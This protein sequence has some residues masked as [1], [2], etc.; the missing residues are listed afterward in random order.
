MKE[1]V[2]LLA[3]VALAVLLASGMVVAQTSP[4]EHPYYEFAAKWSVDQPESMATDSQD[5]VYVVDN[6]G[7]QKFAPDGT[8]VKELGD[9]SC[10]YRGGIAVDSRDRIYIISSCTQGADSFLGVQKFTSNG[11]LLTQWGTPG[12]G[13]D[14]FRGPAGVAVDSQDNVYV[15]DTFEGGGA[16]VKKFTSEGAFLAKWGSEGE[17][18]GQFYYPEDIAAD[19]QDNVYV[20]DT[21]NNRVQKFTSEGTFVKGWGGFSNA[22]GIA[23]DSRDN[24]YVSDRFAESI[25]RITPEGELVTRWGS[26]GSADGKFNRPTD[27]AVDSQGFAYVADFWN[28]RVQKFAEVPD[29]IAPKT[30][31]SFS[32][33]PNRFRRV[34]QDARVFL[35]ATD[36]GV[37]AKEITYEATG[38]QRMDATT[39]SGSS[40]QF[41]IS[42]EGKTTLSFYA[43]DRAGN[44]ERPVKS[45]VVWV[46]KTPPRVRTTKPER[47]ATGVARGTVVE[48]LFTEA[49][50]P[51]KINAP[52]LAQPR[53]RLYELGSTTPLAATVTYE[54][55]AR[56][57]TLIPEEPLKSGTTYKASVIPAATDLAYNPLDQNPSVDGNQAK[58]WRFTVS[59]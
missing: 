46:D 14:Q 31:A 3:S 26:D 42:A 57:A 37:G 20:M 5:N 54:A 28:D 11:A 6:Y 10:R 25:K 59:G 15:L 58:V 29:T 23:T 39:A 48:A 17:G 21:G 44:V 1:T 55:Q 34:S 38:A 30:T 32:P 56:K 47:S 13:D 12:P 22:E 43:T 36:E 49:M 45:A 52:R 24:I 2:L 18:E 40:A 7:T 50:D 35:S 33:Y 27:V 51:S 9:A 53:L 16:R 4:P 19:S 41:T 8:F